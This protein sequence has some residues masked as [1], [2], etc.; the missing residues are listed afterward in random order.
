[1]QYCVRCVEVICE[2]NPAGVGRCPTCRAFIKK[3]QVEGTFAIADRTEM[4]T[5]CRQ[6]KVIVAEIQGHPLCDSCHMGRQNP[7][8]YECE[9]CHG[10]QRIPHPLYRYQATADAFSTD[11]WAC[12]VGCGDFTHWRV[13]VADTANVPAHDA[14]EGWGR[15]DEWVAQIRERRRRERAEGRR[16]PAGAGGLVGWR[17]FLDSWQGLL[18]I[19]IVLIGSSLWSR[20]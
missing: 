14:P 10:I 8:R 4:C 13:I 3:G 1:M 20:R 18:A 15:R 7:L 12:H 17:V 16:P 9:R 6:N 11:T 2:T 5:M 19:F